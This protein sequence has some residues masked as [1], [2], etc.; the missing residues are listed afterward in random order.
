[1]NWLETVVVLLHGAMRAYVAQRAGRTAAVDAEYW[2][3]FPKPFADA[4]LKNRSRQV[5]PPR[6]SAC[7]SVLPPGLRATLSV[8]GLVCSPSPFQP[9]YYQFKDLTMSSLIAWNQRLRRDTTD[10]RAG[11]RNMRPLCASFHGFSDHFHCFR[12]Y[13][14]P[15][16]RLFPPFRRFFHP[17][18]TGPPLVGY[19]STLSESH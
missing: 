19:I 17:F 18:C 13:F 6:T 1:M 15:F 10:A 8:V 12:A 5:M 2:D 7:G 16:R 4:R 3:A 14:P 9:A 11:S